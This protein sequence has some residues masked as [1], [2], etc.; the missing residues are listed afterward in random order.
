MFK[1]IG[2]LCIIL[3]ALA[4]MLSA[5]DKN[6]T[7]P[8]G[9]EPDN[10]DRMIAYQTFVDYTLNLQ[11]ATGA[12]YNR[13]QEQLGHAPVALEGRTAD[14]GL[15]EVFI[16]SVLADLRAKAPL[17]AWSWQNAQGII[18]LSDMAHTIGL[19]GGSEDIV[20][21]AY[22]NNAVYA[23]NNVV[24]RQEAT[25]ALVIVIPAV[26]QNRL[27]GAF[28]GVLV[29]ES[30]LVQLLAPYVEFPRGLMLMN[31][32][33]GIILSDNLDEVGRNYLSDEYYKPFGDLLLVV[34]KM[35]NQAS[36]LGRYYFY[37]GN[38]PYK[39][40]YTANWTSVKYF[41]HTWRFIVREPLALDLQTTY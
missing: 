40:W 39:D 1:K 5:C 21:V 33:G 14:Q 10:A 26:T 19:P 22:Q 4:L 28:V 2:T 23:S 37:V 38:T 11:Q 31:L 30:D 6:R 24:K 36:G 15:D 16:K 27:Y 9:Q 20:N 18:A 32:Q 25:H 8:A 35:R 12:A 7:R 13:V 41:S 29:P 3:L 34:N 17:T